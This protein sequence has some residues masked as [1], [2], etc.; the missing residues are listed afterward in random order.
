MAGP[1]RAPSSLASTDVSRLPVRMRRPR[2]SSAC[3]TAAWVRAF[4]P[5]QDRRGLRIEGDGHLV[6]ILMSSLAL[7]SSDMDAT[8]AVSTDA[9]TVAA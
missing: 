4:S 8:P 3:N 1:G 7:G 5:G 2:P 9:R 6:D